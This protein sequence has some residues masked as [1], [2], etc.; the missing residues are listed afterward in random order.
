[1]EYKGYTA[2]ISFDDEAG[3]FVGRLAGIRDCIL[4]EAENAKDLQGAFREAVDDYL[5]GCAEFGKAPQKPFSGS[6]MLRVAPEAH[7]A[8]SYAADN[9]GQS[10]NKWME[11]LIFEKTGALRA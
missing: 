2:N 6:M 11:A 1:M 8:A 9:A 7:A 10:L 4:F 3:L 5:E